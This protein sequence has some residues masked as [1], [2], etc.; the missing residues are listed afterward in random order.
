MTQD[1]QEKPESLK[2]PEGLEL[3]E[4]SPAASPEPAPEGSE[5]S[6]ETGAEAPPEEPPQEDLAQKLAE[7]QDRYLRLYAEFE[8][9]K[10]RTARDVAERIRYANEQLLAAVLPVVDNLERALAHARQS[11]SLNGLVEGVALTL[12]E[13][14]GVLERF[15]VKEIESLGQAFNPVWHEAMMQVESET[16]EPNTVVEEFQK[17][18][19]L[20]DRVLRPAKVV[21]AKRAQPQEKPREERPPEADP[22][23]SQ[24]I[25]ED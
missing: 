6:P 8:N 25:K 16:H 24:E 21:V 22:G 7:V 3:P 10:K 11:Q 4:A 20:N 12:K 1:G 23:T 5:A 9:Y 2:A 18:Y 13:F 15:G 14:K 17:G 19:L